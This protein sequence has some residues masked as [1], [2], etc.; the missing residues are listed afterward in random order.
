MQ[1][2]AVR[3]DVMDETPV[4]MYVQAQ[5]RAS[6]QLWAWLFV[7]VFVLLAGSI[8]HVVSPDSGDGRFLRAAVFV[9]PALLL[10]IAAHA[11]VIMARYVSPKNTLRT[12]GGRSTAYK[13][14]LGVFALAALGVFV[15]AFA[16]LT[17]LAKGAGIGTPWAYAVPLVVY[18]TIVV[19]ATALLSMALRVH[20]HFPD[21]PGVTS[22]NTGDPVGD[23]KASI[24]SSAL[25]AMRA[26]ITRIAGETDSDRVKRVSPY[27][28]EGR[29][30]KVLD[31][32]KDRDVTLVTVTPHHMET[33][34]TVKNCVTVGGQRINAA[35]GCLST[36]YTFM[37]VA[38]MTKV[39]GIWKL[40][41][42]RASE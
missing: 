14:A 41:G 15:G 2:L 35:D 27:I 30:D 33:T 1:R 37:W 21:Q 5:N 7:S 29:V 3:H 20:G 24:E 6:K 40:Y 26:V 8:A 10:L 4:S 9:V 39:D 18:L 25:E 38:D 16:P 11:L 36:T 12:L 31:R 32:L 17:N 19:V 23:S 28:A 42:V 22:P 34:E 13:V